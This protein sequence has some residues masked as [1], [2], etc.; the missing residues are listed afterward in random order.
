MTVGISSL[1]VSYSLCHLSVVALPPEADNYGLKFLY[2]TGD[3][4][5]SALCNLP[6]LG[7]GLAG[8]RCVARIVSTLVLFLYP[9]FSKC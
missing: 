4:S 2:P 5:L 9:S 1:G 3:W 6:M 8:C 7:S